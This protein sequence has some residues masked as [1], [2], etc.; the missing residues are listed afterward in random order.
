[1]GTRLDLLD[2]FEV[3]GV[4]RIML[5]AELGRICEMLVDC[6]DTGVAPGSGVDSLCVNCVPLMTT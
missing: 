2:T 5:V 3:G 4:V 6:I 1:M